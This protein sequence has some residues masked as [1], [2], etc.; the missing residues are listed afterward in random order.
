VPYRLRVEGFTQRIFALIDVL[1]T[2]GPTTTA[3]LARRLDVS[4]RT[5]RRDLVRLHD[6]DLPI[7]AKPGRGGGVS[8]EP[9]ALLAPLRFTDGELVALGIALRTMVPTEDPALGAAAKR[10]LKRLEGVMTP[11]ARARTQALQGAIR[12]PSAATEAIGAPVESAHFLDAADAIHS[13]RR[14]ALRYASPSGPVTQRRID[15]YGL[16]RFDHWYLAAYCHLRGGMRTFRIDRVRG[17]DLTDET[18]DAPPNV[19]AFSM[20]ASSLAQ[21]PIPNTVVCQVHLATDMER[22]SRLVPPAMVV[23][24]PDGDGVMLSVRARPDEFERIALHLL[25][26]PCAF[27]IRGPDLLRVAL[28]AVGERALAGA[29]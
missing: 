19:D 20:V 25:G 26:L 14:V 24:E 28:R 29:R 4:E 7:T 17:L 16:V 15:P 2:G 23:L 27:E 11:R 9:G 6:L 3:E 22:A 10:A 12:S 1:Q 18:F 8:V 21:A 5:V 13:R